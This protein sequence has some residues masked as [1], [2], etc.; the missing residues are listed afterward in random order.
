MNSKK[1]PL[2]RPWVGTEELKNLERVLNRGWLTTG[3]E[4]KQFE[5]EFR[6]RIKAQ[7]AIA[8]SSGTQALELALASLDLRPGEKVITPSYTFAA[9]P[10]VILRLGAQV[11][12]VDADE[13]DLNISI[14]KTRE[15]LERESGTVRAILPVHLAGH[16]VDI[17]GLDS[18]AEEFGLKIIEDAAHAYPTQVGPNW[19]GGQQN[20]P[21]LHTTCFSFY[22]NKTLTT[23]E[24]GMITTEDEELAQRLRKLT[25]HGMEKNTWKRVQSKNQPSWEYE[26]NERGFKANMSDLA[27]AVGLAQLEKAHRAR[28]LR[29]ERAKQ[30]LSLLSHRKDLILP[31]D[32]EGSSWHLF[33]I[34]LKREA[35]PNLMEK[36]NQVMTD[37]SEAGIE[38]SLHYRPIHMHTYYKDLLKH[39][40][41]D[42]PVCFEGYQGAITL[43]LFAQMT[44]EEVERVV[45]E[46]GKT[47]ADYLPP[48]QR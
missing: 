9:A 37:L 26:I 27:A 32:V 35:F 48:H 16:P 23:G 6:S 13:R 14:E 15:I 1:I 17:Q 33:I 28:E 24:G 3:P 29:T 34:R 20:R 45:E 19:I 30:Y 40:D 43:P 38:T 22:A 12:L 25:L 42:F 41:G 21:H 18:L 7:H 46:L 44:E 11:V 47:L 8:V 10:E 39:Q 4:V 2:A 5:E 31:P 36:R